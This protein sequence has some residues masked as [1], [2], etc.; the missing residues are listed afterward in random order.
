[1]LG[2]Y[3]IKGFLSRFLDQI[4]LHVSQ[5]F[6]TKPFSSS[7]MELKKTKKRKE[8]IICVF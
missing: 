2:F 4:G 7:L 1:M 5:D 8:G 6:F 3:A